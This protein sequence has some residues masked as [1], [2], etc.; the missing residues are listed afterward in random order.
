ML[1]VQHLVIDNVLNSAPRHMGVI[2]DAAHDDGVVRRIVVA[3][4]AARMV[5]APGHLRASHQ[6]V[7]EAVIQVVEDGVQVVH[8]TAGAS[9]RVLRLSRDS[10]RGEPY[11]DMGFT[12]LPLIRRAGAI[13]ARNE[14]NRGWIN[15]GN[16]ND[17]NSRACGF[18]C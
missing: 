10:E 3:E 16:E 12:R 11:S 14:S 2:E 17:W 1:Q 13:P 4:G 15:S 18:G 5:A 8:L 9:C 7:E 6:P